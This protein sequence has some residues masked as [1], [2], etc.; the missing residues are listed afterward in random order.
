MQPVI[1]HIVHTAPEYATGVWQL[2]EDVLRI[3]LGL[4]L[5][6]EDLSRDRIN[7]IFIAQVEDRVIGCVFLQPMDA[8][9]IQLRAMAVYPEW[10]GRG[11]GAMLVTAAEEWAQSAG[12]RRI[13]LHARKV[14]MGFYLAIG[15]HSFGDQF[16]EVGIPHFMME[17]K[18]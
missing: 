6:N 17:K 2:R 1:R 7:E 5:R 16:T 10:Q 9:S 8:G 4:S 15:Y 14:A 11:V 12:Y 13:E 3:P 18:L